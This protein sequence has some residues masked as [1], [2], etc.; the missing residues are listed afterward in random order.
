MVPSKTT[1]R[2]ARAARDA[3]AAGT[4]RPRAARLDR[5][6]REP[7]QGPVRRPAPVRLR[8]VC[9]VSDRHV[10][11]VITVLAEVGTQVAEVFGD[12]VL[13]GLGI[14]VGDRLRDALV[15]CECVPAEFGG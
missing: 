15:L 1:I 4:A 2:R 5:T 11:V 14:L 10:L 7:A 13:G 3:V 12:G 9:F 8:N 6:G